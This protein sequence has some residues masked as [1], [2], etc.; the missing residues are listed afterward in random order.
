MARS[1][2]DPDRDNRLVFPSANSDLNSFLVKIFLLLTLSASA[3]SEPPTVISGDKEGVF[4]KAQPAIENTIIL[5]ANNGFFDKGKITAQG[6]AAPLPN[7]KPLISASFQLLKFLAQSED[8]TARWYFRT[9]GA[10][11]LT[12]A[13]QFSS[14]LEKESKWTCTIG[15]QENSFT[16][17]DANQQTTLDFGLPSKKALSSGPDGAPPRSTPAIKLVAARNL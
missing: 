7:E 13:L 8:A 1:T 14:P 6:K 3:Q 12:I 5:D 17:L 10:G 9:S 15:S 16:S 11:S 4:Y 2:K